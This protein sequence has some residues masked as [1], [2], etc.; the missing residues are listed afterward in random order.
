M[1]SKKHPLCS[2]LFERRCQQP[3]AATAID[4]VSDLHPAT[5]DVSYDFTPPLVV[6]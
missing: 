5:R 6:S 3:S 4:P 1:V 2:S